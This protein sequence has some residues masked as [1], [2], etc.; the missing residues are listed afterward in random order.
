MFRLIKGIK[1]RTG[2]EQPDPSEAKS[3]FVSVRF[4]LVEEKP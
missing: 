4:R 3:R 2:V 1:K